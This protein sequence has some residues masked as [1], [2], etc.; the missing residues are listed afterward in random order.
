M[1]EGS[2]RALSTP[3]AV[4]AAL[5]GQAERVHAVGAILHR[6]C[7]ELPQHQGALRRPSRALAAQAAEQEDR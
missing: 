2:Y 6:I 3:E 1:C 5:Q 4:G 7:E